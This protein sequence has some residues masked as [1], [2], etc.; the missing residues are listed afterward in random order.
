MG[1]ETARLTVGTTM[2]TR[3]K[4]IWRRFK[5]SW[6]LYAL[7][8]LPLAYILI[9][10][11]YPMYGALIA[12]KDYNPADGILGSPWAG[13]GQFV[14]FF[15]SYEFV[16]VL[17][18]TFLLS[19]YQLAAG[20]PFP[21]M[22]A[23]ALNYVYHSKFKKSVQMITYAPHFISV[24]VMVG[25]ILVFLSP[26]GPLNSFLSSTFG[27]QPINFM[28]KPGLFKS[29]FVWSGVWQTVGFS[30]IIY[31][32]ALSSVNP[33]LHEAAIVDGASKLQRIRHI[34]IPGILAITIII[35]ILDMGSVLDTGFEKVFLMQ[36]PLNLSSSEVIDTY[37]YKVG[38][39]APIPQYSYAAAVG[40]F[41]GVI[42]LILIAG[43]NKL[44]KKVGTESLW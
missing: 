18:N 25:I 27:I 24:V 14:K 39:A 31:L 41:K 30:C 26:S 9:F 44:A 19:L 21:I 8:I 17:R 42:A 38:L 1:I 4:R 35:M 13:F 6:Q 43:T 15:N 32:A 12:F 22:L 16:N 23:L 40:L 2:V 34:D 33:Q 5:K 10:K 36:N 29:I 20:I 3:R 7:F 37:V 28:G 11:Y